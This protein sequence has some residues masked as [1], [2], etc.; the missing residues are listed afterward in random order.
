[1]VRLLAASAI[2]LTGLAVA[3]ACPALA[4]P[5]SSGM[6]VDFPVGTCMDFPDRVFDDAK[7]LMLDSAFVITNLAVVPCT[8]PARDYRVVAQVPEEGQCGPETNRVFV[9]R[10]MV[11]L[12]TVQDP[13]GMGV[14]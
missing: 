8:D 10:D 7:N 14:N 13:P 4:T 5:R 11:T 1:M 2:A 9:T 6:A 12:C 3:S